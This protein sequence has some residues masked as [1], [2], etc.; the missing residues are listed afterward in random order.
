MRYT[1]STYLLQEVVLDVARPSISVGWGQN[2]ISQKPHELGIEVSHL[3]T[4][5]PLSKCPCMNL[6]AF[7]QVC[8]QSGEKFMLRVTFL[9]MHGMHACMHV[10]LV[11]GSGKPQTINSMLVSMVY[12]H[13][14][15]VCSY[16]V[17]FGVSPAS[18]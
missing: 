4:L 12:V 15:G 11:A 9:C 7:G 2:H 5:C 17:F 18:D 1:C 3:D 16:E 8:Y 6:N 13:L 10:I 14:Y